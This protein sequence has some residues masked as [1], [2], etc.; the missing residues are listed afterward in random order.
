MELGERCKRQTG[1]SDRCGHSQRHLLPHRFGRHE[2][3]LTFPH[4]IRRWLLASPRLFNEVMSAVVG[5]ISRFYVTYSLQTFGKR[6]HYMRPGLW[7]FFFN[8]L[9]QLEGGNSVYFSQRQNGSW[10]ATVHSN[11]FKNLFQF[12]RRN[13][14]QCF[15]IGLWY[16]NHHRRIL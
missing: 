13:D 8:G 11:C 1:L 7:F 2:F 14:L 6:G 15:D 10:S 3:V 4:Q 12:K 5:E 9:P 16:I